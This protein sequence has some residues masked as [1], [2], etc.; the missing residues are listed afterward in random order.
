M[1]FKPRLG[2][3]AT[4]PFALCI[5]LLSMGQANATTMSYSGMLTSDDQVQLYSYTL[6][7]ASTV[8][9]ETDSYGGGVSNGKTVS[10]GGFVPVLSLFTLNGVELGSDGGDVTCYGG[11]NMDGSTHMC[12]D[13]YLKETLAAGTY[14]L[15]V[16]EF[17]NVPV[18]PNLSDGFLMQGMGNFTG[19]TCGTTGAF[20]ETD[21]APCVQRNGDFSLNATTTPEPGTIWLGALPLVLFG[22][23]RRKAPRSV[24]SN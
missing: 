14:K 16:T 12:N 23:A 4:G 6:S 1:V 11:M 5:G 10:A 21:V 9:F 3:L 15:A 17:F 18:G 19:S 13:A 8:V 2:L 22:L 7:Q 24:K 20:W